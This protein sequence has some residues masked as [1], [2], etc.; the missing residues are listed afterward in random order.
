MQDE[1]DSTLDAESIELSVVMPCLDE[2]DTLAVCIR[3]ALKGIAAAGV[4][5]EVIVADNGSK[6]G[7]QDI[8]RSEGARV[9]DVKLRGYGNALMGGI[10]A[11]RGRYVIMGDADD[12]Y[13]FGEIPKFVAELRKGYD[14][15]QGCRLPTGGGTIVPGA[16]PLL[17]RVWGNPMFSSMVRGMFRAPIHDVYCGMRG[18]TKAHYQSLAQ[19]CAGMEFAV[20]MI[21][22]SALRNA[23]ISEVPITLHPDGR[24]AHAPHLRTFRDGWRTLRFFFM[25]SPRWLFLVPGAVLVVLGLLG[26]VA[27]FSRATLFGIGLGPA[28][29]VYSSLCLM[30]GEQSLFFALFA[31]YF[32]IYDGLLP[33]DPRMDRFFRVVT[34]EHGLLLAGVAALAGISLLVAMVYMWPRGSLDHVHT[35][36]LVITGATMVALAAQTFFSSFVI[37]ILGLRRR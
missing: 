3:K 36:E 9:I 15:V 10:A 16:M 11:A 33:A 32:A 19:H 29:M 24:K 21:I 5:G 8:A 12:S 26:F 2:K 7:S 35:M 37:S 14:L 4:R 13:D 28:A 25:L 34:L 31:K 6:D 1:N 22:K 30:V 20:E 27:A 18:F 17:H 23:K